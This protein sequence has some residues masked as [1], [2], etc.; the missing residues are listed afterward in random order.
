[1]TGSAGLAW[2]AADVLT[3]ER[4]NQK[5]LF[6]GTGSQINGLTTYAG[7]FAY[8]TSS[9]SGFTAD[10]LY[11]RNAANDT[12][13]AVGVDKLPYLLLSTSSGDYSSGVSAIATST[14]QTANAA[15]YSD[16]F[17]T[18]YANQAAVDTAWPYSD[19]TNCRGNYSTGVIDYSGKRDTTN[20]AVS[21]YLGATVSNT[22]WVMRFKFN[23]TSWTA[24]SDAEMLI[25]LSDLPYTTNNTTSQDCLGWALG[26]NNVTNWGIIYADGSAISIDA[27][28]EKSDIS[29]TTATN[30]YVQI[31]RLSATSIEIKIFSDSAYE[32][33][34]GTTAQYSCASTIQGL[35]YIKVCNRTASNIGLGSIVATIDDFKIWDAVTSATLYNPTYILDSS[36][37][38]KWV[39]KSEASPA[40]YVDYSSTRE[41]VSTLLNIDTSLTTVTTL[42][43]RASTS[44]SFSDSNNIA[45]VNVSDFTNDTSRYLANNFLAANT[46]YVQFI[47][48]GTGVLAINYTKSRYGVSDLVKILTHKHSTRGVSAVDSFTDSN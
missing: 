32:T 15:T 21:K 42:K 38:T 23:L 37:S 5:N 13:T 2:E 12:W 36:T 7:Q 14:D 28:S 47:G 20:D 24:G 44:T 18:G 19:A 41:F 34:I 9:G 27:G 43:I 1:M 40:V 17:A 10:I 26:Y 3:K 16:D 39:S 30:Y 22:A 35:Q 8:C 25:M 6:V 31:T 48:V 11:E 46:R 33:Q 29:F 4:L 45:Y